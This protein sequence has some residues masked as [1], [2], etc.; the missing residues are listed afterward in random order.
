MK[1]MKR[2]L[3]IAVSVIFI[4]LA[5]VSCGKDTDVP[6]GMMICKKNDF[7]TMFVPEDGWEV[8]ETGSDFGLAQAKSKTIVG[9]GGDLSNVTV[10]SVYY[11]IDDKGVEGETPEEKNNRLFSAYFDKLKQQLTG[12]FDQIGDGTSNE[13]QKGLFTDFELGATK[14]FKVGENNA[15]EYIYTAK[16]GDL[17]YKYY[18]TVILK[19][20]YYVI[21][22]NFPQNVR[23]ENGEIVKD[24]SIEDVTFNDSQYEDDM[25]SIV[26]NF[27]PKK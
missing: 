2:F 27:I 16:Y 7:Y 13:G 25:E 26:N 24:T 8:I 20:N 11:L 1:K 23:Q 22:F 17:Y 4:V 5:L 10:N 15:R 3:A 6:K 12:E 14:D 18:T 9:T 21:T 19:T